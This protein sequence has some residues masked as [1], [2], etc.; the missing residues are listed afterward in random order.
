MTV[1]DKYGKKLESGMYVRYKRNRYNASFEKVG[2]V[3]GFQRGSGRFKSI[4]M[5][6]L[7][8]YTGTVFRKFCKNVYITTDEDAMLWTLE[9]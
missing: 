7:R 5:V 8:N 1:F 4:M 2:L 9:Q 3:V 6:T